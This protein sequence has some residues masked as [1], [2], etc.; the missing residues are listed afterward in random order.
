MAY[1]PY[2][3]DFVIPSLS[4]FPKLAAVEKLCE[5]TKHGDVV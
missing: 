3:K 4:T 1:A 5:V 2:M